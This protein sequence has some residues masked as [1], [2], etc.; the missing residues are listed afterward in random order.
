L[1]QTQFKKD[2]HRPKCK[3]S[4]EWDG[5]ANKNM[6]VDFVVRKKDMKSVVR[7]MFPKGYD[8]KMHE[9]LSDKN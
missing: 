4:K 9:I 6:M 7:V 8:N 2:Y 3:N 1:F 5:W